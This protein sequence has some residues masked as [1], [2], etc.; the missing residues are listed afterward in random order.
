MMMCRYEMHPLRASQI[1][2]HTHS[3]PPSPSGED[4]ECE[5]AIISNDESATGSSSSESDGDGTV[6]GAHPIKYNLRRTLPS[7]N[8]VFLYTK[9]R[10]IPLSFS[11]RP[12]ELYTLPS[13]AFTSTADTWMHINC[14]SLI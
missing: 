2:E 6:G 14:A 12:V 8:R 11:L 13:I 3:T 9:D 7:S 5:I 10:H 4:Y 1:N